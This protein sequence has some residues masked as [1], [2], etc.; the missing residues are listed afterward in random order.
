MSGDLHILILAASA[1]EADAVNA[2]LSAAGRFSLNVRLTAEGK[3]QA[4]GDPVPPDVI[5]ICHSP[6]IYEE[7]LDLRA[8]QP[9]SQ[10]GALYVVAEEA[11]LPDAVKRWAGEAC[12]F[13]SRGNLKSLVPRLQQE[14]QQRSL[15]AELASV[16]Q[17]LRS[18]EENFQALWQSTV[19]AALLT[20]RRGNIRAL[21]QAAEKL[22]G[23][24][25]EE[26]IG[27][28]IELLLPERLR[29]AHRARRDEFSRQPEARPMGIGREL[30]ACRRDGSEFPVE[31][32]LS[33]LRI[34]GEDL[35]A[36]YVV[37][38]S[39]RKRL[40]E[41][42]RAG[43][44]RY[45]SL[46]EE[47][48]TANYVINPEGRVTACNPAYARTFGFASPEEALNTSFFDFWGN[49]DSAA[50]FVESVRKS[51]RL[52]FHEVELCSRDGRTIFALQNVVGAFDDDENLLEIKGYLFDDTSRRE[53][54]KQLMQAQKMESMGILA[55]G[56]SHDFSNL[57]SVINA[58]TDML[59]I[60][61]D[62][63]DPL[64]NFVEKISATCQQSTRL[65]QQI[66][67]FSRKQA[68]QPAIV[69]INEA[70]ENIS[71][72]LRRLLG[73]KIILSLKLGV[74]TPPVL[75]DPVQ[76][77]QVIMN[78]AVNSRDA[79]PEGGSLSIE[80]AKVDFQKHRINRQV[81]I[82]P[83]HYALLSVRDSGVGMDARIME[84]IFEPFFT[85]KGKDGGTGLGLST[86]Y[87][88]VKQNRG[89]IEVESAPGKGALFKIYFPAAN[90]Q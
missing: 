70:I 81:S 59:L 79:M 16:R 42:L 37:D 15:T 64:R 65:I 12:G 57:I 46:F 87:G 54:E 83:G 76:V 90:G 32:G 27:Q 71:E 11:D 14:Q 36:G 63:A 77:E 33:P 47:A 50:E 80:T 68:V 74:D 19:Q 56:I 85:T 9:E 39:T 17:A 31:I 58:Y 21:N 43:E 44:A 23:Y 24:P 61:M 73:K 30:L 48:L 60:K 84:R 38:I 8:L 40:E 45:R 66:L 28:S 69:A 18:S 49:K 41:S 89:H 1:A 62:E 29:D 10:P 2:A 52:E 51:R 88:I 3:G 53:V 5:I 35:V 25:A 34:N 86:V 6:K 82:P 20:D 4:P 7:S 26:L 78:L 22:F 67:A 13:A 72:I 75:I 55:G